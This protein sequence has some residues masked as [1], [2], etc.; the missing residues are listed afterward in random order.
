MLSY[1][2]MTNVT[3]LFFFFALPVFLGYN[4]YM[5]PESKGHAFQDCMKSMT[6]GPTK[7]EKGMVLTGNI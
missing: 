3:S 6:L 2:Y 7:H 5:I 4:V 1:L